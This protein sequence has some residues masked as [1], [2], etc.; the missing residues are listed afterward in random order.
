[1]S[2]PEPD[3]IDRDPK[4]IEL[5]VLQ[6]WEDL[7]GIALAPG[8][9]EALFLK[10]IAYRETLLRIA[11]QEAAKLNL[12][13]Y[14]RFPMIDYLG[15]LLVTPRLD[16]KSAITTLRFE[17]AAT[18]GSDVPI[19]S[20]TRRASRD[21]RVV[22]ATNADA[23][24][25]TGDLTV[26]VAATAT[27]AGIA[28]NGY[29]AGQISVEVDVIPLV[30][31]GANTTATDGGAPRESDERYMTRLL[32][33]PDAFSVAGPEQAYRYR[34][35]SVSTLIA[36][37]AAL[38]P[39]PGA[40][41]IVVLASTGLPSTELLAAV[42]AALQ[43][44]QVRPMTDTVTVV[45]PTEV[46]WTIAASLKLFSDAD[47]DTTLAAAQAAATAFADARRAALGRDIVP[48]QIIA[49]LSVPGVYGV[50]LTDPSALVGVDADEWA[51][52]T[53][54]SVTFDSWAEEDG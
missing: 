35:L 19:P 43:D 32:L 14:S 49:A 30:T 3:F 6:A 16:A 51:N 50:T 42:T 31:V 4:Q 53:S 44:G 1:M 10:T 46:T 38:S 7:T 37:V 11:I 48:S 47:L 9:P 26:D 34:A 2:L 18:H 33:A 13:R 28:A 52:C 27:A 15:D 54:V 22:F 29:A 36:D 5:D 40:V 20:G 24:I 23:I 39:E 21:G 45:A 17:L 12:L 25:A 41:K 8:D